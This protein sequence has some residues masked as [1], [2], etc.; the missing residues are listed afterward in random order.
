M[1]TQIA[2]KRLAGSIGAPSDA[3]DDRRRGYPPLER[4][5]QGN[6]AW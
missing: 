3:P 5:S 6:K 4:E 1:G 2:V